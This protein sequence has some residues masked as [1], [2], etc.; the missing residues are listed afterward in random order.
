M[1]K[2]YWCEKPH[3]KLTRDHLLPVVFGGLDDAAN[4]VMSC[5]ACNHDRSILTG[6]AMRVVRYNRL[7]DKHWKLRKRTRP[8]LDRL[9]PEMIELQNKWREIETKNLGHSPLGKLSINIKK[10]DDHNR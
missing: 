6:Y 4:I 7:S 1:P 5:A 2:C 9:R 10:T 3:K 8:L